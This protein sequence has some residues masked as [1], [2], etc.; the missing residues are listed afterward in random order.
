MKVRGGFTPH[1]REQVLSEA[2]REWPVDGSLNALD[3]TCPRAWAAMLPVDCKDGIEVEVFRHLASRS[4]RPDQRVASPRAIA[5][6]CSRS[7]TRA[8]SDSVVESAG[9]QID[10]SPRALVFAIYPAYVV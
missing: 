10:S 3:I 4:R 6:A 2:A 5:R 8:P 7:A 9:W 1:I